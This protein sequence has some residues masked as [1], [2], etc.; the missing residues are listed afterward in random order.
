[1]FFQEVSS[2]S[3]AHQELNVFKQKQDTALVIPGDSLEVC[4]EYFKYKQMDYK[5]KLLDYPILG[6]VHGVLCILNFN[7]HWRI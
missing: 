6:Y 4:L 2:R 5:Y 1:M 3:E 7:L